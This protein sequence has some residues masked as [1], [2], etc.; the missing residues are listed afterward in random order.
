MKSIHLCCALLAS[1]SVAMAAAPTNPPVQVVSNFERVET[2][3]NGLKFVSKVDRIAPRVS[4]SLQVRVGASDETAKNAG[5]R[6]LYAGAVARGVPTSKGTLPLPK[7]DDGFGISRL[8]ERFGGDA[9]ISVGDDLIEFWATGDSKSA[10]QMLSL[11]VGMWKSSRLSDADISATRTNLTGQIDAQDLD[12]AELTSAALRNQEFVNEKGEPVSYGLSEVGTTE[13]LDALTPVRVRE[14][15]KRVAS[16]PATL[17]AVGDVD[18]ASLRAMLQA[19]PAPS[20][21]PAATPKFAPIKAGKPPFVV[22]DVPTQTAWV[23]ISYPLGH[24]S[25]EDAPALRVLSAALS[26]IANARLTKRLLGGALVD[27]APSALSLSSQFVFR[28]DGSE[29]LLSAQTSASRVDKVKNA[30]LDEVSKL[31]NAPLSATEF[32]SARTFARGDWALSRQ[33]LRDRAFLVGQTTAVGNAPD[34]TWPA[35]LAQLTPQKTQATAKRLF[36]SY[37][38]ALVMP[39]S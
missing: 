20:I 39:R 23:F 17:S 36:G 24:V 18:T 19:L 1:T 3:S 38:V 7:N 35:R 29:L 25:A 11:L 28:R 21:V 34:G 31:K 6:R 13:S 27:G 26:D 32:E 30:L 8:A 37:A 15:A 33:S 12:L 10:P 16:S 2:L 14:L 4:L 22:R 9:G 5:W